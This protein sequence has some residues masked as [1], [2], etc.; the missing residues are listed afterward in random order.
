MLILSKIGIKI[1]VH[2]ESTEIF[3]FNIITIHT[4][5]HNFIITVYNVQKS[6]EYLQFL[7]NQLKLL[8]FLE[9]R[10][11]HI[12]CIATNNE[13]A[14]LLKTRQI[15]TFSNLKIYKKLLNSFI[16]FQSKFQK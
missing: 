11:I 12:S 13:I 7:S 8:H 6:A 1:H 2:I 3:H 10:K 5:N 16:N 9:K 4:F 14:L 15:K